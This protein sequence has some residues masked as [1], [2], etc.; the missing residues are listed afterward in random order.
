MY[1]SNAEAY[2]MLRIYFQCYENAAIATRQYALQFPERKHFSRAVFSRLARR[3]RETG[4]VHSIPASVRARRTRTEENI[5]NVLAYVQYDPTLSTRKISADLGVPKTIVHEILQKNNMHPYHIVLH[6]ALNH[7]DYD[8]R[9]NHCH[10]LLSMIRENPNFLS[11]ILWTDEANFNNTGG[12]NLH[13]MHYW[14]QNNPHWI[15]QVEHQNRWS[16]NVWCGIME[17]KIIGPNFFD[18]SLNGETFL[19]FLNVYLP[20]LLEDVSLETRRNMWFQ[21]DGCPAHY[22]RNVRQHLNEQYGNRVI[23][24]GGLFPWPARSPDL[25]CLDFYLWGRLKNL[26]FQEKPTTRENMMDRIQIAIRSLSRAEIEA[27]V[28]STEIRLNKCIQNDGRNF[29]H[30]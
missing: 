26:F 17:G 28:Y 8:H 6:Q 27:A 24:R 11:R 19:E 14:S 5:I 1:F 30:L 21:L 16:L 13:N 4:N 25:T 9:L 10:W 23:G 20:P 18:Q 2:D 3:L 22:D 12:V 29:E 7:I 15:R